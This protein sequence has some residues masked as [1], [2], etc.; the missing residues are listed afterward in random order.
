ML[1]A[2]FIQNTKRALVLN[3]N[4]R[5]FVRDYPG[6]PVPEETFTYSHLC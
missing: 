3:T 5:P 1:G 2:A 6:K 4:S